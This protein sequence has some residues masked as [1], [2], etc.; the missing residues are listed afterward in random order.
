MPIPHLPTIPLAL[1][2]RALLDLASRVQYAALTYPVLWL[3]MATGFGLLQRQPT[4]ALLV[5]AALLLVGLARVALTRSMAGL[6]Q[7]HFQRTRTLFRAL[8]LLQ[9]GLWSVLSGVSQHWPPAYSMETYLLLAGATM[10]QGGVASMSIDPVLRIAFPV[11]GLLPVV[12]AAL[13]RGQPQDL[14][15]A[16]MGAVLLAYVLATS[17]SMCSDYWDAQFARITA[18]D[19]AQQLERISR[20]D[21]LT[22]I[23]NRLAFNEQLATEWQRARRDGSMVAVAMIDLD[24]FKQINDQHGHPVGDLCLAAAAQALRS[25]LLRPSDSVARYGGEE[26]VALLPNTSLAGARNT[27]ERLAA[28]LRQCQV[29]A[30]G[31]PVPLRC[32]IGVHALAPG[33]RDQAPND[34]YSLLRGADQALYRAKHAGRDRVEVFAPDVVAGAVPT[35]DTVAAG[36]AAV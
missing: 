9:I 5:T 7:R 21:A 29:L 35:T 23:P 17:R 16:L 11:T 24:H 28:S 30:A 10:L 12:L 18:Q 2:Q 22:A 8:L 25:A 6:V 31:Q 20:T 26:F 15:L 27:A 34:V 13:L 14:V 32:S 33:Q 36:H 19:R 3:V 1:Q 4:V